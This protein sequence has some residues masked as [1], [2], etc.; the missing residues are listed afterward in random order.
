VLNWTF[1][2]A[3]LEYEGIRFISSMFRISRALMTASMMRSSS[4]RADTS[5]A[6]W[7]M[8]GRPGGRRGDTACEGLNRCFYVY[9][10]I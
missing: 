1:S 5:R 3:R 2:I 4:A 9:V 8:K 6:A 10:Y 7:S